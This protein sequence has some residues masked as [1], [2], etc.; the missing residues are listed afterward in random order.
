MFGIRETPRIAAGRVPVLIHLLAPNG[1]PQQVT[2]DLASFWKNTYPQVKKELQARYPKHAWPDN[3]AEAV[4]SRR[5]ARRK[6]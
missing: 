5:P 4:P 1:R 2:Q 3:P 6:P